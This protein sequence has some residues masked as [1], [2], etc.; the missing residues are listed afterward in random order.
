MAWNVQYFGLSVK[1]AFTV[2][3]VNRKEGVMKNFSALYQEK[4]VPAEKAVAI[5]KSDDWVDYGNFICTPIT[6]DAALAKRKEEL[7]GVK[8]RGVSFPGL[9]ALALAD[10]TGEHFLY[11]NY[12]FSG[13]D[14][15]LHDKGLCSYGPILYHEVPRHYYRYLE[16]DVY[17][18][19]CS[20]MDANGFFNC[21]L[22]NSIQLAQRTRSKN[23]IV[24]VNANMPVCLGGY[25]ESIHIS[26]VR[27]VVESANEALFALPEPK[28]TEEDRKIAEQIVAMMQDGSCLQLGIGGLPNAIGKMIAQSDL[29]DLGVHTEMLVDSYL[30]MYEAGR[31]TNKNKRIAPGKMAYTFA[32]GSQRFYEFLNGNPACASFPVEFVNDL[33]NIAANPRAVS[34]NNAVEVDLYGQVSSES[35]GF[36]HISG[37]GGQFDYHY[38]CYHSEEG[39]SFICLQSTVTDKEGNRRSRIV[40]FFKHGTTVTLPRSATHIVVTEYGM[41]NLKGKLTW[42]RAEALIAI[43]H[44][45]FRE[46][47]MQEA[48]KMN[49][50]KRKLHPAGSFS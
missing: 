1:T 42:E 9:S 22:G 32:I 28:S 19:R 48:V 8:I 7:R 6:L 3:F 41:A 33:A 18:V 45:D 24:E 21:G 13:G 10:P 15:M 49:I 23:I 11:G 47:L 43:A 25:G 38:A 37:T 4:L 40:P 35:D 17:M 29:K 31:I 26:E 5:V 27:Y 50:W 34:I 20:P 2:V 46:G 30:D 39:Q 16:N 44:P 36:R 12:H 14:R